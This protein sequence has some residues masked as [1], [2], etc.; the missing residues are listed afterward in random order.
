MYDTLHS[1]K[2][3]SWFSGWTIFIR[4]FVVLILFNMKENNGWTNKSFTKLLGLLKN[5]LSEGNTLSNP[6]YEVNNLLCL[7]GR[8]TTKRT[9]LT[10]TKKIQEI[11]FVIIKKG[12][13]MKEISSSLFGFW[14]RQPY[15][16]EEKDEDVKRPMEE[17]QRSS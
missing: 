17:W 16:K 7:M 13:I 5:M 12:D 1:D 8:Y 9:I 3:E 2:D 6:N 15:H 4:M 10:W 11:V 14:W